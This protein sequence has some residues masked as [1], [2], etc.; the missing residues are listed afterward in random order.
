MEEQLEGLKKILQVKITQVHNRMSEYWRECENTYKKNC[1]VIDH[2]LK[3]YD[4]YG[5]LT[6]KFMQKMVGLDYLERRVKRVY[7]N[8]DFFNFKV[9]GVDDIQ[10]SIVGLTSTSKQWQ[11]R[12]QNILLGF[13]VQEDKAPVVKDKKVD[14]LGNLSGNFDFLL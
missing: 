14:L 6:E 12:H 11:L 8:Y 3:K 7:V 1:Y 5:R 4:D 13:E 2:Y 9:L 10:A